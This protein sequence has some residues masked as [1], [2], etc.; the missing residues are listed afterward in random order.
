MVGYNKSLTVVTAYITVEKYEK[1]FKGFYRSIK[2]YVQWAEPYRLLLNPVLVYT[3]SDVFENHMLKLRNKTEMLTKIIRIDKEVL[4]PFLLKSSVEALFKIPQYPKYYPG[5]TYPDY[6]CATNSKLSIL[7]DGLT[8]F[9]TSYYCWLDA[10]YLKYLRGRNKTF[11]LDV[12]K[13]FNQSKIGATQ[14]LNVSLNVTPK[15]I[16]YKQ[17]NWIAGGLFLG[18]P[19]TILKFEKQY[20]NAVLRFLRRNLMAPE[21]Q[22]IYAMYSNEERRKHPVDVELQK[23]IPGSMPVPHKSPWHFLGYAMYNER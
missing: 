23:Y 11:T 15:E 7:V 18:V 9:K 17:L 6:T 8:R 4:W 10:G 14:A 22:I 2:N 12:P 5:T 1:V 21:Q 3:D 16:F 19:E 13:N 20:R